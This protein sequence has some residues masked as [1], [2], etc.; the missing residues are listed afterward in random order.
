MY[1]TDK[2]TDVWSR[3]SCI[4]TQMFSPK[5][6]WFFP[7]KKYFSIFFLL[8]FS[9][10]AVH[11][12]R[13][14]EEGAR[15]SKILTFCKLLCHRKCK[16]RGVGGQKKPKSC[17]RSLW[18][19][20]YALL[21]VTR[22][23]GKLSL[24]CFM[25]SPIC[26]RRNST[27]NSYRGLTIKPSKHLSSR[28]TATRSHNQIKMMHLYQTMFFC[29]KIFSLSPDDAGI[30][31]KNQIVTRFFFAMKNLTSLSWDKT[32]VLK[33]GFTPYSKQRNVKATLF[34]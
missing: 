25:T 26:H 2:R 16:R 24:F 13:L 27:W 9:L 7:H 14:Q 20:P 18:K 33:Y 11:K 15:W 8:L 21:Y 23:L 6:N 1:I 5:K 30:Y 10:G 12:L 28:R 31:H 17:Q 34:L 29:S 22:L 32:V 3:P 4:Y 19:N